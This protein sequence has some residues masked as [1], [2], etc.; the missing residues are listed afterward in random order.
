MSFS[1]NLLGEIIKL[2]G[3]ENEGYFRKK[4]VK[5]FGKKPL[6]FKNDVGVL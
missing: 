5:K 6:E 3:Y 4:F 2:V 1:I